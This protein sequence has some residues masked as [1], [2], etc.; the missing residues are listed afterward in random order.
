[1]PRLR[2][3]SADRRDQIIF[4]I[5][6]AVRETCGYKLPIY[7]RDELN[8]VHY[9]TT[10]EE[11]KKEGPKDMKGEYTMHDDVSFQKYLDGEEKE[12]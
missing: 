9:A 2:Y 5:L 12:K 8:L 3:A 4:S 7:F 1:M 11:K 10:K 6:R